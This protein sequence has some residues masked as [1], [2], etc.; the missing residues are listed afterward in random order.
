M[1][2][3]PAVIAQNF[4]ALSQNDKRLMDRVTE[5][6]SIVH[7]LEKQ[8]ALL[9]QELQQN[10]QIVATLLASRTGPTA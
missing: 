9:Q 7:R 4:E 2:L 8:M 1:E 5:A 6:E 10:K 3:P